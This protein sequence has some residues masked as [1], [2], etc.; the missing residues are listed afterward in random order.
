MAKI[1]L[2]PF[3]SDIRGKLAGGIFQLSANGLI[4][5]NNSISK[6]TKSAAQINIQNINCLLHKNWAELSEDERNRFNLVAN[7]TQTHLK[8]NKNIVLTGKQFFMKSNFYF[9][10]YSLPIL[11]NPAFLKYNLAE[12]NI[13][14]YIY[15]YLLRLNIDRLPIPADEFFIFAISKP[16]NQTIMK[17]NSSY[18]FMIFETTTSQIPSIC[19]FYESC[20]GV[21][22]PEASKLF[23]KYAVVNKKSG[24]ISPF[25]FSSYIVSYS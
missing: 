6:K 19:F 4:L 21:R 14:V 25:K 1:K 12:F 24:A 7:F 16:Q 20:Y 15:R 13:D 11:T 9:L 18:R 17:F 23:F 22:P 8:N 10:L 3:L 5:K 2:S